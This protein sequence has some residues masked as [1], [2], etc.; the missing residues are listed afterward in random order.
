MAPRKNMRRRRAPLRK[1]SAAGKG[2]T[3]VSAGVKK[4]VK[5]AIDLEVEDKSVQINQQIS[6]GNY[7]ESP[8]FNAF[9]MCPQNGYW[10]IGQSVQAGSRLG[11]K[12]KIKSVHL[13]YVL[14][15]NDYINPFNLTPTPSNVL[16]YLGYVKNAPSFVPVA[17]DF[18]QFYQAGSSVQAPFGTL[19]DSIAI[20]NKDYWVIK[21]RWMEKIGFASNDGTGGQAAGQYY[22][23]N[24]YK[25]NAT[26]RIDITKYC[27]KTCTFND[28]ASGVTN[29]NLYFM[30]EAV[31]ANGTTYG[32]TTLPCNIDYWIDFVYQDA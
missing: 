23:N 4:Y 2:K 8:E 30:F 27:V 22:S 25:L 24:D 20:L 19:K 21:K 16:L 29:R 13:N 3:S 18:T 9:P 6:F 32:A 12:I 7:L 1:R 14:R 15:P 10:A 17:S 11:N 31:A 28:G 26:R 5:R